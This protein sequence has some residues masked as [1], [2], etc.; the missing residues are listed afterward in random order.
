MWCLKAIRQGLTEYASQV[1]DT[2][3]Q[4]SKLGKFIEGFVLIASQK[5]LEMGFN[6]DNVDQVSLLI[7]SGTFQFSLHSIEVRMPLFFGLQGISNEVVLG[8][9]V[10]SDG[11]SIKTAR[12][13]F[14]VTYHC[15]SPPYVSKICMACSGLR[16]RS[17]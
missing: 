2:G 11:D 9:E 13:L 16:S 15:H 17:E 8:N 5:L 10:L 7:Q 14:N 1:L 12:F 3:V 4:V 6:L